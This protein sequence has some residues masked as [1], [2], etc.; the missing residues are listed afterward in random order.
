MFEE[1][2]GT[3]EYSRK[4]WGNLKNN[5]EKKIRKNLGKSKELSET[6]ENFRELL[7]IF[8]FRGFQGI[9]KN[10]EFSR[11]LENIKFSERRRL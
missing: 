2:Q 5:V 6:S 3:S 9:S 8:E 11:F 7:E 4:L 1:L 10:C